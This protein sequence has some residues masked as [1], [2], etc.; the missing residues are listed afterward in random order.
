LFKNI[1]YKDLFK[2]IS[3]DVLITISIII[4]VLVLTLTFVFTHLYEKSNTGKLISIN[5]GIRYIKVSP[6]ENYFDILKSE[7]NN[8]P[9]KSNKIIKINNKPIDI[10]YEF[11]EKTNDFVNNLNKRFDPMKLLE[12]GLRKAVEKI[13]GNNDE[14]IPYKVRMISEK[15]P[16]DVYAGAAVGHWDIYLNYDFIRKIYEDTNSYDF[17]MY[18]IGLIIH[19]CVHILMNFEK[20]RGPYESEDTIRIEENLAEYVRFSTGYYPLNKQ[21]LAKSSKPKPTEKYGP[22]GAWFMYW[23]GK[24]YPGILTKLIPFSRRYIKSL[25]SLYIKETGKTE[26]QLFSE[27]NEELP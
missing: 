4:V 13:Y 27:F 25:D 19:E 9:L 14:F 17:D 2:N 18:Y 3:N 24:T 8:I 23:L 12:F 21:Y 7:V 5:R 26:A 1:N 20:Y 22:E 6:V 16:R 11:L 15:T 10:G